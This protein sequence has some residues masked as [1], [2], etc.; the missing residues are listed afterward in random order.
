MAYPYDS[1]QGFLYSLIYNW[2]RMGVYDII[3]P[4]LLVFTISFAVLQKVK[5]FGSDAKK[6][7]VVVALVIGLLFLQNSYLIFILQ[8]FLPNMSIVMIAV[9]MFLLLVGIFA[10]EYKGF[11][12]AAL[13]VAF[14]LSIIFTLV[15][16][17]TD[18]FPG[19]SGY[20]ILDWFYILVPDPGTQSA[21]VLIILVIIIIAMVTREKSTGGSGDDTWGKRFLKDVESSY[22]KNP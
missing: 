18:F 5:I 1:G 2:Q 8:R 19:A 13:H 22:K 14:A 15:A 10:G 21:I 4:F 6:I 11:G 16:L 9:L 7:N 20:G 3:L 12:G 17:S